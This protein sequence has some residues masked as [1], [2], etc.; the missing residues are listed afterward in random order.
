VQDPE[1][2]EKTAAA[3]AGQGATSGAAR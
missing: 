1:S 2:L 3:L